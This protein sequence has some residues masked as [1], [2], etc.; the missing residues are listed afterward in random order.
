[1]HDKLPPI[2]KET[3]KKWI[4]IDEF[5]EKLKHFQL[6]TDLKYALGKS[7]K[8]ALVQDK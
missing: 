7:I 4:Q 2:D 1:M 5:Q 6:Q 3:Q 8:D